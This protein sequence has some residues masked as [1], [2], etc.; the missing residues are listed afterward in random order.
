MWYKF[1]TCT[2]YNN[3]HVHVHDML[4][5]MTG[6]LMIHS[7]C[8]H[9]AICIR[10]HYKSVC[11]TVGSFLRNLSDLVYILNDRHPLSLPPSLP[12]SLFLSL[13]IPLSLRF[14]SR[15]T[16]RESCGDW[17]SI[18][19]LTSLSLPQMTS[20]SDCGTSPTR[21]IT[22]NEYCT[23]SQWHGHNDTYTCTKVNVDLPLQNSAVIFIWV[24]K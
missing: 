14:L 7:E 20:Y 11:C 13:S 23:I 12:L 2:C 18:L 8:V 16:V 6:M 22:R 4:I 5:I 3:A 24:P 21:C 15:V 10:V 19:P 1:C 17:L 9:R